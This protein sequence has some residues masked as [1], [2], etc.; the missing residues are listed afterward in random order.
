L[1]VGGEVIACSGFV[2]GQVD[3][4][5]ALRPFIWRCGVAPL[6]FPQ[7]LKEVDPEVDPAESV[8]SG[9]LRMNQAYRR[10]SA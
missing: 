7:R 2:I 8:W 10:R 9:W 1:L 5:Q 3:R 6:E 4:W